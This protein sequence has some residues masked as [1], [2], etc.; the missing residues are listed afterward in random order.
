M[1]LAPERRA[2]LDAVLS[3]DADW[4]AFLRHFLLSDGFSFGLLMVDSREDAAICRAALAAHLSLTT[5]QSVIRLL[6]AESPQQFRELPLFLQHPRIEPGTQVVWI[7]AVITEGDDAIDE[8]KAAWRA[9]F[10]ALNQI[11]NTMQGSIPCTLIFAGAPWVQVVIRAAAPDLW[12]I[13]GLVTRISLRL[14]SDAL[15]QREST[16]PLAEPSNPSAPDPEFALQRAE[17]L[18]GKPGQ[19]VELADLLTRAGEGFYERYQLD[20]AIAILSEAYALQEKLSE[21]PASKDAVERERSL[22]V[23]ANWLGRAYKRDAQFERAEP[24]LRHALAIDE[25]NYGPDHSYVAIDLSNLAQLLQDTNRLTEAEPLMRRAL[26]IDEGSYGPDHPNVAIDLNNLAQLLQDTNRLTEAESLMRRVLAIDERSHGSD[27]PNVA[28][29]LN[30]LALLLKATN[31]LTEAELLMRR[32]L[33]ID[34]R[35][36][37]LDH[38]TVAIRL[39][40]LARLLQDTNRLAEAEPLMRR[41]LAIDERSYGPDH[42]SVARGFSNLA[43]LLK[44]TSRPTESEPL[45]RRALAIDERSYGP[46]HPNVARDLNNLGRLLQ[47]TNRLAEAEPLMRRAVRILEA[48][49]RNSG[50]KAPNFPTVRENYRLLTEELGWTADQI[51]KKLREGSDRATPEPQ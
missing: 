23:T 26:A 8:W 18:R 13:R 44:D 19:E 27:H 33:A 49:E 21:N 24:F 45:M 34:E 2:A 22:A 36:Y 6:T 48:F 39:N 50:F 10:S 47:D 28:S 38:P 15:S 20:R 43:L 5:N 37:G 11:R 35:S 9:C 17:A 40:N 31:R 4:Q 46:D 51:E 32:A 3:A 41:A 25:R 14:P 30:N 16:T 29:G 12:S 7:D 42:P 1:T